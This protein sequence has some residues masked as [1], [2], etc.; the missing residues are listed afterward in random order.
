MVHFSDER[1]SY[2]CY[3]GLY[4][5]LELCGYCMVIVWLLCGADEE[6]GGITTQS[7]HRRGSGRSRSTN[8]PRVLRP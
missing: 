6:S 8:I 4:I 5:R 3:M 1:V 7:Y 2:V